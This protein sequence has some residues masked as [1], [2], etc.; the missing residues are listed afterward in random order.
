VLAR[1]VWPGACPA[2]ALRGRWIRED[3][4]GAHGRF[5]GLWLD[6]EG[7]PV[8]IYNGRFWTNND[9]TREFEGWV[10]GLVTD[11]VIAEFKGAWCYYDPRL[12]PTCGDDHGLFRGKVRFLEDNR[13]GVLKGYFG[14]L[15]NA[16][17]LA[18]L[19]MVGVWKMICPFTDVTSSTTNAP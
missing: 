1:R 11:Q 19:P 16:T 10:S 7:E 9:H 12:C 4:S 5:E 15:T 3:N 2:G 18:A 13:V 6:R 8:G 14:D 17:D